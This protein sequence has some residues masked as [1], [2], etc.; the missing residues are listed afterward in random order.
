MDAFCVSASHSLR[1]STG[2]ASRLLSLDASRLRLRG[3]WEPLLL[4]RNSLAAR[5]EAWSAGDAG[6]LYVLA[7]ACLFARV[8][9]ASRG[10]A[11]RGAKT[12]SDRGC[13]AGR[14]R[15]WRGLRSVA[16]ADVASAA[17]AAAARPDGL[18]QED[19]VIDE[20]LRESLGE[21]GSE[22]L[23]DFGEQAA[24]SAGSWEG[25]EERGKIKKKC[26]GDDTS[27]IFR[28]KSLLRPEE[29]KAVLQHIVASGD[30]Y[31]SYPDSVDGYPAF[32]FYPL[33]SGEW[34]DEAMKELLEDFVDNRLLPYVRAT[35][36]RPTCTVAD[37]L[38][39]RYIPGERRT[40]AAHFDGQALVTAVLGL[41]NPDDYRGGLYLQPEAHASSRRFVRTEPGDLVVHSFDLQH[42]VFVWGG[43]RYS[44]VFWIKDSPESVQAKTS[45]WYDDLAEE[46][47]VDAMYNVAQATERG[48]MGREQNIEIAISLYGQS[49]A[50]GHHFAQVRLA[51]LF[52]HAHAAGM[53]PSGLELSRKWLLA[54]A[55][56]G[57]SVAQRTL[58][59]SLARQ[60]EPDPE[61]AAVWMRRA[62]EQLDIEAAFHL[63]EFLRMGYGV[64]EDIPEAV[65]WTSRS[66]HSGHPEA[67]RVLGMLALEGA[68][69]GSQ[70]VKT[71]VKWLTLAAEQGHMEALTELAALEEQEG[72]TW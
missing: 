25:V 49:A 37:I 10:A 23:F 53:A 71:A 60:E 5:E 14:G 7:G 22:P 30:S 12:R 27:E 21:T 29:V 61:E 34:R 20:W 43:V 63:G 56:Q 35:Y 4:A 1:C 26:R 65:R 46:G 36:N 47:D 13:A 59:L 69:S 11:L 32:E 64:E 9:P 70:D 17:P 68:V 15:R 24:R 58:A 50:A 48:L 57:F 55:N 16:A 28:L 66:A 40:H 19:K 67:Q 39:R 33:E 38:V 52:H 54:A 8:S 3:D 42:G 6:L 62:A 41:S 45:P 18:L 31:D 44:M 51:A 2:D 72:N